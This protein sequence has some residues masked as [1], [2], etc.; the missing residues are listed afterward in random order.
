MRKFQT[1][2]TKSKKYKKVKK[3]RRVLRNQSP[4]KNVQLVP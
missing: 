2:I 1:S 4:S 3:R